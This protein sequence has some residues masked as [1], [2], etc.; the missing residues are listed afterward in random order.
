[1]CRLVPVASGCFRKAKH[2]G[3][4][5]LAWSGAACV[6]DAPAPRSTAR[7]SALRTLPG[8]RPRLLLLY[9]YFWPDEVVSARHY[10][11]LAEGLS[12]RGWDVEAWPCNRLRRGPAAGLPG[13]THHGRV[14][15]RRVHRWALAQGSTVGRLG[16][17]AAMLLHWALRSA[18]TRPPDIVL[19]GSDPPLGH[20]VILARR[21]VWPGPQWVHWCFDLYPEAAKA[22]GLLAPRGWLAQALDAVHQ[23]ALRVFD[24]VADLGPGMRRRLQTPSDAAVTLV[25]WA[26]EAPPK[27]EQSECMAA[28]EELFGQARLGL[29][30]AGR[31]GLAHEFAPFLDL[32]AAVRDDSIAFAFAGVGESEPALRQAAAR[33]PNVRVLG[34]CDS[35]GFRRRILAADLHMVSVRRKWS[36]VVV[37]T[38]FFEALAAGRGVLYVGAEDSC[39]A[40]WV[41]E[42]GLGVAATPECAQDAAGA[43]RALAVDQAAVRAL[44]E[45]CRAIS[46]AHFARDRVLDEFDRRLRGLLPGAASAAVN[47]SRHP[48]AD[49]GK[50]GTAA[51][52][53]EGRGC[54][55]EQVIGDA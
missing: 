42:F 27:V 2:C 46:L 20:A 34:R 53:L 22:A 13:R 47:G 50:P 54:L 30:Y 15:I 32:A 43:L 21:L 28:R 6:T 10:Q 37:P 7:R 23:Q 38:K 45:R 41:R 55:G 9:H 19:V 48:H 33:H 17:A 1:M 40:T 24:L 5:F 8:R 31:V 4:D 44:G 29:L 36:G 49:K 11:G 39:V 25:P 12:A 18:R 35:A 26:L 3:V 52:A 14:R 16:N 51:G